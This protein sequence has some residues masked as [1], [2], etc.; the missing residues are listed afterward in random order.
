MEATCLRVVVCVPFRR[1]EEG[2]V[3]V[4]INRTTNLN[5]L[6]Y[7]VVVI[8]TNVA[9]KDVF[10]ARSHRRICVKDRF[11]VGPRVPKACDFADLGILDRFNLCLFFVRLKDVVWVRSARV[12]F[13]N[14]YSC[15]VFITQ[16]GLVHA[17]ICHVFRTINRRNVLIFQDVFMRICFFLFYFA[18]CLHAR[19]RFDSVVWANLRVNQRFRV[20]FFSILLLFHRFLRTRLVARYRDE[21]YSEYYRQLTFVARIRVGFLLFRLRIGVA[22]VETFFHDFYVANVPVRASYPPWIFSTRDRVRNALALRANVTVVKD[23]YFNLSTSYTFSILVRVLSVNA[24]AIFPVIAII[25]SPFRDRFVIFVSVGVG[26]HQVALAF[27]NS[28]MLTRL[29]VTS[30]C[31]T[32][33][34]LFPRRF[35]VVE[36]KEDVLVEDKRRRARSIVR[37]AVTMDRAWIRLNFLTSP[38]MAASHY[39][40]SDTFVEEVF[41]CRVSKAASDVTIRVKYGSFTCFSNLG[42]V[43]EGRIRL[44]IA[45]VPFD[46]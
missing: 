22:F 3:R 9:G 10:R 25:R 7:L 4:A 34:V 42:R 31:F 37:R 14:G 30:V 26:D 2:R 44:R 36:A 46:E 18:C 28:G 19:L 6:V 27:A 15:L 24:M 1:G 13:A 43:N 41:N 23:A 32:V 20:F 17:L 11:V 16:R 33:F 12:F 35:D 8:A 40:V 39:D 45:N 5:N 29:V 38:I 21:A